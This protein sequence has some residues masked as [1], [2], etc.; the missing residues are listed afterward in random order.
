MPTT[1]LPPRPLRVGIA[2]NCGGHIDTV[3]ESVKAHPWLVLTGL[4]PG[5]PSEDFGPFL[6]R[7][8]VRALGARVY[9]DHHAMLA[10]EP[11]ID[12]LGVSP[13]YHRHAALCRDALAAGVA[14][15]CEKPLALELDDLDSLQQAA[16]AAGRPVGIMLTF[17]YDARFHTARLLVREGVI[18][19]PILG[20]AQKAYRLGNRPAF[21]RRR[22]LI[23]GMIPWVGIHA[24]DWFRWVSGRRYRAVTARHGNI[25]AAAYPELE[26]H[27]ACLFAL[28]NGGSAVFSFDYLRPMAAPTH[29]DDRLR[30]VGT[31]GSIDIC[32]NDGLR[33]IGPDGPVDVLLKPPPIDLFA[34]FALGLACPPYTGLISTREAFTITRISLLAR[35]AADTGRTI[36]IEPDGS[37][38]TQDTA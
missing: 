10:A 7:E 37:G 36:A 8:D 4:C 26:D 30:L 31:R 13:P 12:I 9:P 23:G 3:L 21:Y 15:F 20:Y 6:S 2:G 34:D 24:I 32:E 27:A 29:G 14:P 22:A 35:L 5:D 18:G 17:R 38:N 1:P 19:E 16:E 25:A 28:D 33:V 11:R